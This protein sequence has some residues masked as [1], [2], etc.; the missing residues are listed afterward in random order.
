MK[1]PIR[2]RRPPAILEPINGRRSFVNEVAKIVLGVLI[3]L[4]L[5]AVATEIGWRVEVGK[6]RRAIALELGETLGQAGERINFAPCVERRLDELAAI[7]DAS[8]ASGRTPP[9][10]DI[11]IPPFRTWNRGLWDSAVSSQAAAHFPREEAG[12]L[13]GL[14]EFVSL[15]QETSRRELDAWTRLYTLIGPGRA[16]TAEEAVS[17]RQAVSEA[18]LMH[19]TMAMAA[20]RSSQIAEAWDLTYD[21]PTADD[22]RT[23]ELT[24]FPICK[25]ISAEIPLAYGQ[26]PLEGIVVRAAENPITR[27]SGAGTPRR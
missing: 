10:G 16:I 9:L 5:G 20:I 12:A 22:Y 25:P 14:N 4:G 7:I 19:R 3:A 15:M 23:R 18:R 11:A 1:Q 13:A 17:M 24:A 27:F 8:A 2:R 26:A 21:H 6:A